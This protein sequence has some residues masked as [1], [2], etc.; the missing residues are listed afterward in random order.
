MK[1]WLLKSE[2]DTWSWQ[3]QLARGAKGEMWDGVR[4]Y[5]AAKFLR[6]M[7]KGDLGFFYHS[8]KEKAIV[9][10]VEVIKEN[11]PDPTDEK[12]RFVAVTVKALDSLNNPVT[13]VEIKKENKLEGML[14]IKQGRLSVM[15]VSAAHWKI[16]NKMAKKNH[17]E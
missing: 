7:K 6:E 13:L 12:N 17:A 2:P 5:Q 14:L 3:Q 10:I 16:I 11:Y 4:N 8:G 9:G 15:P 1:Y